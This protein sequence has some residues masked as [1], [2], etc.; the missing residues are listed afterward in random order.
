MDVPR[1]DIFPPDDDDDAAAD[2]DDDDDDDAPTQAKKPERRKRE[3]KRR[4]EPE[5][6][7]VTHTIAGPA[8]PLNATAAHATPALISPLA[9]GRNGLFSTSMSLSNIWLIPTMNAFPSSNAVMPITA[10]G[11]SAPQSNAAPGES[12]RARVVPATD[13]RTVPRMVC[14]R[15]NLY[16]ARSLALTEPFST[17]SLDLSMAAG[18]K[19]PS[20]AIGRDVVVVV[21]AVVGRCCAV[22][23]WRRWRGGC[24]GDADDDDDFD[25]MPAN[26]IALVGVVHRRDDGDENGDRDGGHDEDRAS[27][28]WGA[29]GTTA[30][31]TTTTTNAAAGMTHRDDD[32]IIIFSGRKIRSMDGD[33]LGGEEVISGPSSFCVRCCCCI[34]IEKIEVLDWF[35]CC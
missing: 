6:E 11:R 9:T 18:S 24:K 27:A 17:S 5:K 34:V 20:T 21:V 16:S 3:A 26:L 14:G 2:D 28:T 30:T 10:R 13:A 12:R 29:F 33:F 31:R 15:V 8:T 7:T 25:G 19:S 4:T 22:V 1:E 32:I 23:V 35:V